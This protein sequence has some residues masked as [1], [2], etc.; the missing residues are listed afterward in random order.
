[1]LEC[2]FIKAKYPDMDVI[3]I[4][5]TI[6]DAHA[7]TKAD[8]VP[9]IDSDTTGERTD[10]ARM[11]GF[12]KFVKTILERLAESEATRTSIIREA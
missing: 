11:P 3:S 1:M 10:I 7:P 9:G 5:P 2:G 6:L 4:G 12:W 8:F